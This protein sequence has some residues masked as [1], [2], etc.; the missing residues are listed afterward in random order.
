MCRPPTRRC[1]PALA[2][3]V[4]ALW[5]ALVLVPTNVDVSWLIVVSERLLDGERL[6]V[7]VMEVNPPFSVWL[8]MPFVVLERLAGGRA[9]L[10]MAAGVVAA[11]LASVAISARMLVR[12]DPAYLRPRA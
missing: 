2:V 8:Y 6:T 4:Y 7:D 3:A 5:L 11:G 12:Q 10:W 9:E 1:W